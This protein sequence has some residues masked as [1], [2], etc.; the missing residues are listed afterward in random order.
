MHDFNI[1]GYFGEVAELSIWNHKD[2]L[3]VTDQ[4]L[5]PIA[6]NLLRKDDLG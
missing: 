4:E 6:S 1:C 2:S 3:I 5:F